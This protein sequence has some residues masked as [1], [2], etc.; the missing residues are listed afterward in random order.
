MPV[1]FTGINGRLAR[2]AARVYAAAQ[3]WHRVAQRRRQQVQ[4]PVPTISIGNITAGGSGKTAMV[5]YIAERLQQWG[6]QPAVI[7]RGYLARIPGPAPVPA[8]ASPL[9]Y[10]DEAV[11]LRRRGIP[12]WIARERE[13]AV[14]PAAEQA[15][16][17]LLDDGF[18]RITIAR[19]MD[20]VGIGP[21]GLGNGELLPA[22]ILREPL[23]ALRRADA[24]FG[25]IA[26]VPSGLMGDLPRFDCAVRGVAFTP[27][28]PPPGAQ[29]AALA[30]IA[31]PSVF[32]QTL[33]SQ[34]IR[35][36][37]TC[38]L[39]DHD[40]LHPDWLRPR[41]KRW[42]QAGLDGVVVTAKDAVKLPPAFE[43]L[44]IYTAHADFGPADA[45]T[46]Q[47][48]EQFIRRRLRL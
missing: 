28:A 7:S 20:L 4:P 26:A 30:A 31:Y 13:A 40:P 33:R 34:G 21:H 2:V 32:F 22:G 19:D 47:A 37:D 25:N 24:L 12:V 3:H 6:H 1:E 23:D 27:Q 15:D 39:P 48:F 44:P 18:Q 42:R 41:I 11:M 5:A 16:V 10:G 36:A 9:D 45:N 14:L 38:A 35:L 17:L 46:E 8:D 29:L 43:T